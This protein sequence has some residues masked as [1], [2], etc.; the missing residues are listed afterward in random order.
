MNEALL[1]VMYAFILHLMTDITC[2]YHDNHLVQNGK[3]LFWLDKDDPV[4]AA[5]AV[6]G[7][8]RPG[9]VSKYIKRNQMMRKKETDLCKCV[10][11]RLKH[12]QEVIGLNCITIAPTVM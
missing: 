1:N 3:P 7:K 2:G 9:I 12:L 8:C 4:L 5:A 10:R 11:M 6:R